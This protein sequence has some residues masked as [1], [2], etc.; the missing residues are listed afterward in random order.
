MTPEHE[1]GGSPGR[2]PLLATLCFALTAL[3][4]TIDAVAILLRA[5]MTFLVLAQILGRYAFNYAISWS[6]ES[7]TFVQVWLVALGAGI[8]MRNRQHVGIDFIIAKFP[9][10]VQS[11][12][13][14]GGLILA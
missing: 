6:E 3:R 2:P 1:T 7:A 5:A 10:L 9:Y 11:I 12:V 14:G 13:K 8:A 4:R